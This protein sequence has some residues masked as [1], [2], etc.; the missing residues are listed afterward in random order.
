MR[1][2]NQTPSF[3]ADNKIKVN[4]R[5]GNGESFVT[6]IRVWNGTDWMDAKTSDNEE[7][8]EDY[9]YAYIHQNNHADGS[10]YG[11]VICDKGKV[12]EN[13]SDI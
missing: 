5:A 3:I 10:K 12:I 1:T 6:N 11:Y 4:F 9:F 8:V 2:Q 13:E 7:V